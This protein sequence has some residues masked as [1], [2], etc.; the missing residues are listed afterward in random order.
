MITQAKTEHAK[1]LLTLE[2]QLF[3]QNDFPMSIGSFYYH[4]KRNK[5]FIYM[6]ENKV[7]AYVLWLKRQ[8]Y[9]RL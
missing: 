5:L 2:N 9:Y 3:S 1:A 7:I 6:Q 4:I 8:K